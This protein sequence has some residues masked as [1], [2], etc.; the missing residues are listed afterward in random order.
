MVQCGQCDSWVH[1]RCD[2]MTGMLTTPTYIINII[3]LIICIDEEYE[4]LSDLPESVEYMCALCVPHD[5]GPPG[6]K[7]AIIQFKTEAYD[8]VHVH[9]VMYTHVHVHTRTCTCS[10]V[11]TR[12]CT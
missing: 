6:W 5:A 3:P 10:H 11:H 8:K 2:D 1:S 9:V 4:I 7:I 12:T